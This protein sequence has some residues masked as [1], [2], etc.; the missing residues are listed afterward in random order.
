MTQAFTL[1]VD[2]APAITS[3][4]TAVF[5][6]GTASSFTVTTTGHPTATVSVTG[7]LPAGVTFTPQSDGTGVLAGTPGAGSGGTYALTI[8]AQNGVGAG[9]SQ[10]FVLTVQAA[11]AFTSAAATTFA[12]GAVS[13][14]T[15]TT[16]A[17]PAASIGATGT[18]PP[19]I[20]FTNLGDGTASLAGTP[21]PGSAGTY[22]LVFT[23]S[24]GIGSPATQNFTLT[25][26]TCTLSPAAGS[27]P[28]GQFGSAYSQTFT[29]TGGTGHTFGVSAGSLPAGLAL[30]PAG[31]LSGTPSTTGS[32]GFSVTATNAG[33]CAATH[34]YT[35]QVTPGAQDETF[36]NGVGNTQYSVGAGVPPTPAVVVSGSVLSNDVGPGTLTAGPAV[37]ATTQG[38][39]VT[40]A[41]GGTFLYTPP[42]GFA[43][44]SDTFTYTLTDGN[45]ATDTA[46]V[47]I[48]VSGV[49]WYV[50]ATGG[51]GDGRSHSPFN[52]MPAAATA[53][54]A[55]QVIYVHAGSPAG[56]TVL[57]ASQ[58][59]RG[60]GLPFTL[61][62]LMIPA[63]SAPTLQGTITLAVNTQVAGL[64]VNA[65]A[66][67]AVVGSGLAGTESL[68]SV[69]ITGGT[70]GLSLTSLGG[71]F[72][73]TGGSIGGTTVAAVQMT[74]GTGTVTIG[75]S[76]TSTA[77]ASVD[78]QNRTAG[79][80][81]FSGAIS[82]TAR[83]SGC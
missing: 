42:A 4:A 67:P 36:V 63:A 13:T 35:L 79:T 32:F 37:I 11:P 16:T 28:A 80:V 77:G 74:G 22:P 75:G 25:V 3:A 34:A 39:Q 12:E 43:G 47:T 44:P 49:V 31:L 66:A 57:K 64:T 45:A 56:A 27:L 58:A 54:Q 5:T 69:A 9:A 29:A 24:N 60:A 2:E 48:Q 1:T 41:S 46:V 20:A 19:G 61:G 21:A 73:M 38:G 33:G 8:S 17:T 83:A 55:G 62:G 68:T 78:V 40:M 50:N 6:A 51:A 82:D 70:T 65:G 23:A 18:L 72:T 76:I 14:F 10:P 15:V 26:D 53:A 59:L 81:T 30:S 71:T 52:A 7:S